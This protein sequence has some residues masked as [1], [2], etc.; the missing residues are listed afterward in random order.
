MDQTLVDKFTSTEDNMKLYQQE[1]LTLEVTELFCKLME[2][3]GISRSDL[4]I[5]LKTSKG[6]ITQILNGTINMTLR[7]VSDFMCALDSRLRVE[8]GPLSIEVRKP[9]IKVKEF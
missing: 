1:A 4:A 9:Q 5:K 7:T 6:H 3:K 2:E 8:A